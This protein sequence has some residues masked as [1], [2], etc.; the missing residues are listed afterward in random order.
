MSVSQAHV[1]TAHAERYLKQLCSHWGHKFRVE[2]EPGH[3]RIDFDDARHCDLRSGDAH[4]DVVVEAPEDA[5]AQL[6]DVVAAHLNR[7]AHREG[8]LAFDWQQAG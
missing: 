7:F 1:P 5:L 2:V 4:L 8:A 6:C 3:G